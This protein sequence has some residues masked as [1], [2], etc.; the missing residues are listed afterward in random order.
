MN[1]MKRTRPG[2][3][4]GEPEHGLSQF[5]R[6]LDRAFDR[7]FRAFGRDP[8]RALEDAEAE[9]WPPTDVSEDEKSFS[10]RMDVPGLGPKDVDVEV[11]GDVLTVKGARNEEREESDGGRYR[12]ERFSGSFARSITLPPSVDPGKVEAKYDKGVLTV[13]APKVPGAEPK[14]VPVA[15]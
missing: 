12:H 14:K 4:A 15:G 11:S 1:L 10:V 6:E 2:A 13:T 9:A 7:T 8:W 5:R 3:V